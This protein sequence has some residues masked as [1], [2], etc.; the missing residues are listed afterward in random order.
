MKDLRTPAVHRGT[1]PVEDVRLHRVARHQE[2]VSLTEY[3]IL[4]DLCGTTFA[5]P[6]DL[7]VQRMRAWGQGDEPNLSDAGSIDAAELAATFGDR[8]QAPLE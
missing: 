6:R 5:M 2:N 7:E 1:A 4:L 8:H 3:N